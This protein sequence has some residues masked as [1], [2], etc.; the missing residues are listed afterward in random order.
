[1]KR[2][3]VSMIFLGKKLTDDRNAGA[4]DD[5]PESADQTSIW[6]EERGRG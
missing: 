4:S 5:C 2:T 1:M 6:L 3:K